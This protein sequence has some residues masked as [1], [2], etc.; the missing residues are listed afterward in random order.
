MGISLV[1]GNTVVDVPVSA[2]SADWAPAITAAFQAI[3]DT[4]ATVSGQFDVP[5]QSFIIPN[6]G[7][8]TIPALQFPTGSVRAINISYA[9]FRTTDSATAYETG[10][11]I[12]EYSPSNTI[13]NKWE[14][15][16]DLLGNGQI[17]FTIS[18]TGQVNYTITGSLAGS[19]YSG[20]ITFSAKAL[21]QT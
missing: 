16:Q 18:D 19:S 1:F 14:M 15:S 11:I 5:S 21:L 2:D 6:S 7:S 20:R 9:V 12:A 10:T 17:S 8:G 13:T 3:S 4:L